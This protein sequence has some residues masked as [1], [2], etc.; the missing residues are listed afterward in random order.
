MRKM[1]MI[2]IVLFVILLGG[3]TTGCRTLQ[4]EAPTLPPKPERR[5]IEIPRTAK[6]YAEVMAYYESLVQE[7]ELWG[8]TVDKLLELEPERQLR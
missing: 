4:I 2:L 6:D 1:M 7:W 5:T 8:D 3:I